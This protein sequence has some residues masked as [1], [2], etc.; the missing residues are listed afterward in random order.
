[1]K[2]FVYSLVIVVLIFS[3]CSSSDASNKI[4]FNS[5]RDG[6]FNI[7][8]IDPTGENETKLTQSQEDDVSPII[9]PQRDKIAFVSGSGKEKSIHVMKN[10]GTVRSVISNATTGFTT[11][12]SSPLWAP[13][14]KNIA[15]LSKQ[16]D[17]HQIN[18]V[19]IDGGGSIR[20]TTLNG[21]EIGDW[22]RQNNTILFSVDEKTSMGIYTRNPDGV[23]QF[24]L[25]ETSDYN[26]KWAPGVDSIIF[27]SDRDGNSEIY[28]MTSNGKNQRNL[29]NSEFDEYSIS[30]SPDGN[31]IM[32]VSDRDGNPEIYTMDSNGG[33][34]V[35]LTNNDVRDDQPVWS[36]NGKQIAFVSYLDGDAEIFVMKSDGSDQRR[37]TN[38][39]FH[40]SDPAW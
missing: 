12:T 19:Q 13:D 20:L 40:D 29:S 35:R 16:P 36:P 31:K 34:I 6:N 14:G 10:D 15:Y 32:F 2:N 11:S 33:N 8:S 21:R 37:I 4:Y 1:M 27:L 39:D 30:W 26:A 5:D 23:N 38:N 3:G 25:T 18:I 17:R 22:S 28:S 7:Y 9:S 24:R